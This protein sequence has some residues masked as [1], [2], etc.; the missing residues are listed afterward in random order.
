M[1]RISFGHVFL[2]ALL[3]V[4][5]VACSNGNNLPQ[6]KES[7]PNRGQTGHE[8]ETILKHDQTNDERNRLL[9]EDI[10]YFAKEFPRRHKNPFSILTRQQFEDRTQS[11]AER[12]DRLTNH[13]VYVEL[14]KIIA[15]VGDAHTFP[16]CSPTTAL[17]KRPLPRSPWASRPAAHWIV[18]ARF[19]ASNCPTPKFRSTTARN[20]SNSAKTSVIKMKARE[21]SCRMCCYNRP[22]RT[23]FG[24]TMSF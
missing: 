2:I 14:N 11:L 10:E 18:T 15:S 3:A 6:A 7:T 22:W 13:Q 8:R 1:K 17:K 20:I 16:A 5:T 4:L 9:R 23:I 24:T 21:H 12:V 19:A